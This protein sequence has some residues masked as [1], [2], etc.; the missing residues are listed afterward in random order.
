MKTFPCLLLCLFANVILAQGLNFDWAKSVGSTS[1]DIS[2]SMIIDDF[3]NL[4]IAGYYGGTVDFDPGPASFNMTSS[5]GNDIFIQ[6]Y[7]LLGNFKWA[8][9]IGG[10]NHDRCGAIAADVFGNVYVTGNYIGSADFDPGTATYN[11]TSNGD[12][13]VFITKLD[14]LG[15]FVWANSIGGQTYDHGRSITTDASGNVYVTGNY[16]GAVDFDPGPAVYIMT[17]NDSDDVFVQKL[18]GL[19]NLIWAKSIGGTLGDGGIFITTD[20]SSNVYITG[21]FSDTVDF[22]PGIGIFNLVSSTSFNGYNAFVLKL[23]SLGNFIS[24]NSIQGTWANEGH[25][26]TI[27]AEGNVYTTGY[28]QGTTDFDPGVGTYNLTAIAIADIFI[29]KLDADGNFI[30]AKSMGGPGLDWGNSIATD[31]SGNVYLTGNYQGSMDLDPGTG[32]F[33]VTSNGSG[34][35]F[36]LKL[37]RFGDFIWANSIGGTSG[38]SAASI[39]IDGLGNV[40]VTGAFS[41]TVDFDPGSAA[42]NLNSSGG[43][44][45]FVLKL[46]QSPLDRPEPRFLE[47]VTVFPNP[48]QGLIN[49]DLGDL[50][51]ASVKVFNIFGQLIHHKKVIGSGIHQLDLA[52]PPGVYFVEVIMKEKKQRFKL[53]KK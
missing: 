43:P 44:D 2:T 32:T 18:D 16:G 14:S 23:D 19:G 7:D 39:A 20:S 50:K 36:M 35:V 10:T 51:N 41:G 34:D 27:D 21:R 53:L 12:R 46:S 45:V 24:A 52:G 1:Q 15:S 17:S 40:Y 30:W 11:L 47:G 42:F 25:A 33:N 26:I 37:D 9:S 29:Q 49:I 28:H 4:Y 48:C 31:P 22:D 13:D 8:K 6:K 5:G 38:A 3:G